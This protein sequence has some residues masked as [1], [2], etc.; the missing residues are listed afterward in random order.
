MILGCSLGLLSATG[1]AADAHG[2][3]H[4][5]KP[6]PKAAPAA[7]ADKAAANDLASRIREG[8]DRNNQAGKGAKGE[9]ATVIEVRMP[10]AVT[11]PSGALA[12]PVDSRRAA[13]TEAAHREP[14]SR[15]ALRAKAMAMANGEKAEG[16]EEKED[17]HGHHGS[18]HWEYEGVNGP[19]AWGKMQPEFSTCSLGR[20]QSPIHILDSDTLVGPAEPLQVRYMPS[21]GSVVNNGHTLQVDLDPASPNTLTVRGSTYK[22]IQFH[23]HHPAEEKVNYKGFSM[24]AHLVHRNDQNQLAVVAVLMDPG[25][26]SPLI[27]K[28]WTYMPLDTQDR[29]QVPPGSINLSEL[30]PQ[31]TRYYQFLGSLT[32]PP[33]TEGVLWMVLKTPMTLSTEQLRLFAKLFPNNARPTQPLNGRVVREV[34]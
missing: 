23:F 3:D 31:D 6:A 16:H 22:L 29:V 15:E 32:T 18:A 34:P 2:S 27:N 24:V 28:V 26:P 1:H 19:A 5:A 4:S 17:T 14:N 7:G 8:V 25:P 21:G 30:L 12:N 10:K 33:C 20:R 13:S 9:G 11:K